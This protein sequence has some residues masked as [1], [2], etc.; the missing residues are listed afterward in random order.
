MGYELAFNRLPYEGTLEQVLAGHRGGNARFD[1]P[2]EC[3][4]RLLGIIKKL[5]QPY[6]ESRVQSAE[7]LIQ[8]LGPSRSGRPAASRRALSDAPHASSPIRAQ[9]ADAAPREL[10]ARTSSE[11]FSSIARFF[12]D[13]FSGRVSQHPEGRIVHST[14][15]ERVL[16]WAL[17]AATVGIAAAGYLGFK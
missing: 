5:M 16:V 13:R 8:M 11:D 6:P 17:L 1:Y 10:G 12:E 7:Q 15:R 3:S 9:G 4:Q 2:T 14:M